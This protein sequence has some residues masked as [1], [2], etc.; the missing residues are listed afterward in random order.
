MGLS[1]YYV[2]MR[3]SICYG[4]QKQG[5]LSSCLKKRPPYA[6]AHKVAT[7]SLNIVLTNVINIPRCELPATS[8]NCLMFPYGFRSAFSCCSTSSS[9]TSESYESSSS[10]CNDCSASITS[11]KLPIDL[12]LVCIDKPR[13]SGNAI[14]SLPIVLTYMDGGDTQPGRGGQRESRTRV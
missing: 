1:D 7:I 6:N 2:R 14:S 13:P 4:T 5:H 12:C 11:G 8:F 9:S 3:L 10:S